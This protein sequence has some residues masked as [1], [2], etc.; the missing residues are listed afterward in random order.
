MTNNIFVDESGDGKTKRNAKK[1]QKR[2]KKEL[3]RIKL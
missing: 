2:A 1:I 3:D